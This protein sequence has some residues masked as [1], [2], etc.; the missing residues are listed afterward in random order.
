MAPIP[1]TPKHQSRSLGRPR[2]VATELPKRLK[3][4]P[5][6]PGGGGRY[7]DPDSLRDT[8]NGSAGP[9][10]SVSVGPRTRV[11]RPGTERRY[12]PPSPLSLP[13]IFSRPRRERTS[14]PSRPSRPTPGPRS[15]SAQAAAVAQSDG[16]K[17]REE[18][19]WEEF[20]QHLDIEAPFVV[21]SAHLV[22]GRSPPDTPPKTPQVQLN[23]S[24]TTSGGAVNGI[25]GDGSGAPSETQGKD[26]EKA[27]GQSSND[28]SDN[29]PK[30]QVPVKRR[31]GRPP[32]KLDSMLTGLGS[33]P[34]PKITP[35][36][37]HNPKEK[38]N[39]SKPVYKEVDT[40]TAY[41]QDQRT[42]K[43]NYVDKS[44]A[45]VGY[46]ESDIFDR[47]EKTLHRY[48]EGPIEDEVDQSLDTRSENG[49]ATGAAVIGQVEY[50]MDEQDARWLD[51]YNIQRKADDV[52]GIRPAIFE[53]TMTQIEKEW[54]FLEK[55]TI[56]PR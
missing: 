20:H 32:R 27:L 29:A 49:V 6:G 37:T 38:L 54:H 47:R 13:T 17:P 28:T 1:S 43:E 36:P 46:Q 18:R 52:E 53:I 41:E 11:P 42:K 45:N 12:G 26:Q 10:G 24:A 40:F 39:L 22:D 8:A 9:G 44:L 14:R 34:A 51:A 35:L 2:G 56:C 25:S 15:S 55:R 4:V 19:S 50:D 5:G 48:K 23:A 31:P 21:F 7:V 16:Y 33:P 3:Y 30:I